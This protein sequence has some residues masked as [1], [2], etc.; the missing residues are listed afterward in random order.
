MHA[1]EAFHSLCKDNYT[2]I[3]VYNTNTGFNLALLSSKDQQH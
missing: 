3:E 1:C 2:K